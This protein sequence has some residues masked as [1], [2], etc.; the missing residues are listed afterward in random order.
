ML[1]VLDSFD[2][3]TTASQRYPLAGVAT[4]SIGVGS[5]RFGTNALVCSDS[6]RGAGRLLPVTLDN[7]KMGF[8]YSCG[9]GNNLPVVAFRDGGSAQVELRLN[10]SNQ[11]YVTRNGTTLGTSSQS[12]VAFAAYFVEWGVEIHDTTGTVVIRVDGAVVLNL[13]SQDTR[14][15]GTTVDRFYLQGL[16]GGDGQSAVFDDMYILDDVDSGVTGAPNDNYL[17]DI[18]VVALLPDGN[19]N[20]SDL[21]GSDA[22][23]V[24][25]YLLVD[26]VPPD[27]DTTYVESSTV[28]DKDTYEY[29]DL[30]QTTGSVFGVQISPRA[31]KTDAGTREIAT[32]ARLVAVEV[33]GPN[34]SVPV[35]YTYLT[36][37]REANPDGDQWTIADVNGAEYGVKVTT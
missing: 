18:R 31:R 22:D 6:G 11:L 17:G 9:T 37:I 13:T 33:D 5:G 30:T 34:Q 26:E 21:L 16:G 10:G 27:E 15:A 35:A 23:S 19:G 4:P 14:A 20:S 36:D 25:N 29:D 32:V 1:H 3:Y 12:L 24:D 7:F 28:N 8:A 2:C